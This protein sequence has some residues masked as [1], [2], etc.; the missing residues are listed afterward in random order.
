MEINGE[1]AGIF[2]GLTAGCA[3]LF[4]MGAKVLRGITDRAEWKA[5]VNG[6]LTYL[7]ESHQEMK[8]A[9]KED[10]EALARIEQKVDQLTRS[11]T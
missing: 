8:E 7:V 9:R 4:A 1:Q 10:R 11:K 3:A 6:Q 5:G 2:A